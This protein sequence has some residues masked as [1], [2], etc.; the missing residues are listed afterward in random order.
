LGILAAQNKFLGQLLLGL[1]GIIQTIPSLALLCLLIPIFGIGPRPAMIALLLYALLPIVRGVHS[2]IMSVD[3]RLRESALLMGLNK[4]QR[5][6]FVLLPLAT[7]A[8]MA[9]IKTSAIINVGTATLAAFI[10]AGGLGQIIVTG[11]ALND[12]SLI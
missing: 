8:I 2:G 11:L 4:L 12:Q 1:N 9:G 7:P 3:I 6:R 5:L 10:G